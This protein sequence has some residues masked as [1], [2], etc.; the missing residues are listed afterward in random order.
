M[1]C[2]GQPHF[3]SETNDRCGSTT[4]V[5]RGLRNVR[6]WGQSRH[7]FRAAACLFIARFGHSGNPRGNDESRSFA[8]RWRS[9]AVEFTGDGC[10]SSRRGRQADCIG[11]LT[12][13]IWEISV[14]VRSRAW[15]FQPLT[16]RP[17]SELTGG[18]GY[19]IRRYRSVGGSRC[20]WFDRPSVGGA[21][22]AER[23]SDR[24]YD[25]R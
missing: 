6:S 17:R 8:S 5:Q 18:G 3:K 16:T 15:C 22:H 1:K 4:E 13:A 2:D 23:R 20:S 14:K 21:H 12:G 24:K 19:E 11:F 7:R 10:R 9:F 25:R